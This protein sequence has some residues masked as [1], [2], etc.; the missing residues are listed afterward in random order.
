MA[1]IRPI[2]AP[3]TVQP[4]GYYAQAVVLGHIGRIL[5]SAGSGLEVAALMPT[6]WSTR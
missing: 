3:G 6:D 5:E 2:Q 4:A 1:S